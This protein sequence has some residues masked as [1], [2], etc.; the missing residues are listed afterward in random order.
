MFRY[1]LRLGNC[2]CTTNFLFRINNEDQCPPYIAAISSNSE[3]GDTTINSYTY[4]YESQDSVFYFTQNPSIPIDASGDYQISLVV[5]DNNGCSSSSSQSFTPNIV[6][7]NY[8]FP[9]FLCYNTEF[10]IEAELESELPLVNY[11]WEFG[12]GSISTEISPSISFNENTND[13]LLNYLSVTDSIGCM[14][15]DSFYIYISHP[16]FSYSFV[17]DEAACPPLYSDF[18][19][20]STDSIEFY[21][22]DYGDGESNTVG[23]SADAENISHVYELAGVLM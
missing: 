3:E 6:Q 4:F 14:H 7:F 12:D 1:Y 2:S 15:V 18:S 23:S 11:L 13:T 10:I 21:T 5:T 22:I 20:F 19:L 17:V 16:N 8:N 9:S